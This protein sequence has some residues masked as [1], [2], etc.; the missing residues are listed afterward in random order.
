MPQNM[1]SA[2]LDGESKICNEVY[3]IVPHLLDKYLHY[4]FINKE[5]KSQNGY[6]CTQSHN[7]W[8]WWDKHLLPGVDFPI[9]LA[10]HRQ[11]QVP[12]R[13]TWGS[14]LS[15][16]LPTGVHFSNLVATTQVFIHPP[17]HQHLWNI[18]Y[19]QSGKILG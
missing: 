1:I 18:Y 13:T 3:V 17:I 12:D 10:A 15:L 11:V 9:P 6:R 16:C 8:G 5:I 7:S 19:M 14:P 2:L 4:H